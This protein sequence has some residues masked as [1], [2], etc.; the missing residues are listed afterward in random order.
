[1]NR[2]FRIFTEGNEGNEVP[3]SAYLMRFVLLVTFC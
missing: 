2:S 3:N 1:M